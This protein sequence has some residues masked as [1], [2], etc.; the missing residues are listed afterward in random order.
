MEIRARI[1]FVEEILGTCAANPEIHSEY[2]ASK[3]PDARKIEEEVA[4]IGIEA[5]T[6]KAMTIFPRNPEG[7]KILWA[8][9]VKGFLKAAQKTLNMIHAKGEALYLPAYKGKID[10]LVFVKAVEDRWIDRDHGIVIHEPEGVTAE[11]CQ[12][13]LRAETAQ[14]P[15]VTLAHSETCPAGSVITIDIRTLDDKLGKNIREWLNMGSLY[16][17][18]QWRNSG[19]GRFL[20]EELDPETG[21]VIGGNME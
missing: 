9:Q 4:A 2:I 15:R 6:E 14:G 21:A 7:K 20:W 19:K 3:A 12:R 10:N 5:A 11:D 13:P 1:K 8:Y 16:G 17:I 18:G